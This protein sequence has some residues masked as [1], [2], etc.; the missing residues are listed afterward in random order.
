MTCHIL[1]F[2]VCRDLDLASMEAM[3]VLLVNLPL[4]PE[5]GD[6]GD[7]MEAKSNLFLK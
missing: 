6:A 7:I 5:E 1:W 2:S 4:Q 3:S